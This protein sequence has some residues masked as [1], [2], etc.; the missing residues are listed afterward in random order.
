MNGRQTHSF[1]TISHSRLN[2]TAPKIARPKRTNSPSPGEGGYGEA[3]RSKM[4]STTSAA[5]TAT[6][7]DDQYN[8]RRHRTIIFSSSWVPQG[9][10]RDLAHLIQVDCQFGSRPKP[11]QNNNLQFDA[12][13]FRPTAPKI[14]SGLRIERALRTFQATACW[15]GL[16][17]LVTQRY[18]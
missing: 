1:A 17:G 14:L 4:T 7:E 9:G 18:R 5:R 15:F 12:G 6:L 2:S 16:A 10:M 3:R 11:F 8:E 13:F